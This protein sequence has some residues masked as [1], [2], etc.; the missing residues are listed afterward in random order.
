MASRACSA[1][2]RGSCGCYVSVRSIRR[3]PAAERVGVTMVRMIAVTVAIGLA[4][5]AYAQRIPVPIPPD[6]CVW[7]G[8]VFSN[9]AYICVAKGTSQTCDNGK[10]TKTD[11][12]ALAQCEAPGQ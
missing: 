7:S 8:R 2:R 5:A 11:T 9:G 6:G 4:G 12:T 1:A 10:W 3:Q